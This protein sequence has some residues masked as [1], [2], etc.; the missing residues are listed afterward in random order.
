MKPS[1]FKPGDM[2]QKR[3]GFRFPGVVV[4]AFMTLDGERRYVV[5]ASNRDF[6][7]CLHIC[8]GKQLEMRVAMAVQGVI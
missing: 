5:E 7:G 6:R 2:V 1:E 4:S 8:A 3:E